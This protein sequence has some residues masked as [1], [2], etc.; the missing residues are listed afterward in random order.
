M[1]S[2]PVNSEP[3]ET[4]TPFPAEPFPCPECGQLLAATCQICVACKMPVDFAK[5]ANTPAQAIEPPVGPPRAP[6][7]EPA[8]FSWGIFF[9]VFVA[10]F[11]LASLAQGFL[12]FKGST[13]AMGGFVLA[14]SLWVFV[15]ARGLGIPRPAGWAIA[16]MLLWIVFF[17]WYLSRRRTPQAPCPAIEG[18]SGPVARTLILVLILLTLIGAVMMISSGDLSLK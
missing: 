2:T 15:D 7:P 18:E 10:Y 11:L 17:P 6:A 8:R 13:Y 5:V 12:G 14:T 9:G 1:D 4:A 3:P 16:C